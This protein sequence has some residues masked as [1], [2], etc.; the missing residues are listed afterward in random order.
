LFTEQV[1][2]RKKRKKKG[3]KMTAKLDSFLQK[4]MDKPKDNYRP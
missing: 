1:P 3:L 4:K 2:L